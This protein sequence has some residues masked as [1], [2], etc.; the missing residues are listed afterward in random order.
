MQFK[1][2]KL[3]KTLIVGAL[4][5]G[6]AFA[7][8]A[9]AASS[10]YEVTNNIS[11]ADTLKVKAATKNSIVKVYDTVG[12]L[13][14][15]AKISKDGEYILK[16]KE[17]LTDKKIK[18]TV[19]KAGEVEGNADTL[20]VPA[21]TATT[22]AVAG[23][24][25][26]TN[27]VD[28]ADEVKVTGLTDKA[29]V[30]IT[31]SV[32]TVLGTGKSKGT[33]AVVKLKKNLPTDSANLKIKV[34]V[35]DANKLESTATDVSFSAEAATAANPTIDKITVYNYTGSNKDVISVLGL[36]DKA[37]I[38]VYDANKTK[39]LGTGKASKSGI[40]TVSIAK[41]VI[42]E[43]DKIYVSLRE[44]QKT[45][46]ALTGAVEKT[47]GS[48]VSTDL[49][50]DSVTVSADKKTVT[51]KGVL[52][53]DKI[54]IY[55]AD[56]TTKVKDATASKAG[57]LAIKLT[58]ALDGNIKVSRTSDK[59]T[60]SA[61]KV[62]GTI[63]AAENAGVTAINAATSVAEA[64]TALELAANQTALG[65][66]M[67]DYNA[68]DAAGKTAVA[69]AV[70]NSGTN[71][72]TAASIKTAFDTEVATQKAIVQVNAAAANVALTLNATGTA[73]T[74]VKPTV[75]DGYTIAVKTTSDSTIYD[76]TGAIV[77]SGSSNVVYTVT[78]TASG[79]TADTG[80]VVVTVTAS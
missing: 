12:T 76:A 41:D 69:T 57:E 55:K 42:K 38:T 61:N 44:Y 39:I 74:V 52:A 5:M 25:T 54:T 75:A 30:R 46:V 78:H 4:L 33:E 59:M 24:V 16:F 3:P 56:G 58:T 6:G 18:V 50:S 37:V 14:E 66:T 79:K 40:A 48:D 10:D 35:K 7:T 20:D 65:L 13:I 36:T 2:N 23:N 15:T 68:L 27:N 73:T 80:T 9:F 29:D 45:E 28:T 43:N 11:S 34:Y 77:T 60:E 8:S 1:T 72:T 19:T 53:K 47:V 26:V 17:Q 22:N 71:Y 51:V 32:G 21:A 64:K 70:Y 62:T 49:A 63:T 67:T 31:N